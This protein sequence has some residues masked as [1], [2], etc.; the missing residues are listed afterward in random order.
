MVAEGNGGRVTSV[1]KHTSIY[2]V[3]TRITVFATVIGRYGG[4][5]NFATSH[6]GLWQSLMYRIGLCVNVGH[7]CG[8]LTTLQL[9]EKLEEM[10]LIL[11]RLISSWRIDTR[12][13]KCGARVR[14][15]R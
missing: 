14:R 3:G 2:L 11:S 10:W 1:R 5:L 8:W 12:V 15:G 6:L 9:L 4:E 13:F 7:Q